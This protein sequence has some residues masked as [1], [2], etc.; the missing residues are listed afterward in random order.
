M[1][2]LN[3]MAAKAVLLT[4]AAADAALFLTLLVPTS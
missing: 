1:S 2:L 4:I 3:A